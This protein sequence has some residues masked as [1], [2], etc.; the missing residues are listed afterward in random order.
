MSYRKRNNYIHYLHG[1]GLEIGGLNSPLPVPGARIL[2]SDILTPEEIDRMY[3]GSKHPDIISDSES[4]P[5]TESA[6]FDFIIANHVIEHVTDPI[7]ALTEWHRL[8]KP[9]GI[10]FLAVPD[11]RFTFDRDRQRTPL[12]HLV[13]DNTSTLG[14]KDLNF[15]HLK[16]WATHV[17]RLDPDSQ[18]W[19]DWVDNQYQHGYSVHNHVWQIEDLLELLGHL[20]EK[21][22][23][24]LELI[25][26]NDT[27]LFDL[28]FI[29]ILRKKESPSAKEKTRIP[30][31]YKMLKKR[32]ELRHHLELPFRKMVNI[33]PGAK[34]IVKKIL[35]A[36]QETK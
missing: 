19:K 20:A 28:E 30:K 10:L 34:Q 22:N 29:L 25:A 2:Y 36:N 14:V 21:H 15:D 16:D 8:L 3:P 1:T 35:L 24:F 13:D 6:S 7:R 26:H 9:D 23:I 33:L 27:P 18:E 31:R 17:E 4:F 5:D 12:Q 32:Y 11:K